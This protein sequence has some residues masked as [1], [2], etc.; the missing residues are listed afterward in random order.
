MN[1]LQ[2]TRK[3]G[4]TT[5]I[6]ISIIAVAVY[7]GFDPLFDRVGGGVAGAVVGASFGAIF[8]IVLTMYLLNKQT[9]IEQESKKSERVFDEKVKLYQQ[10]LNNT[11]EMVED[12][13][14]STSEIAQL[15]FLMMELQMLGGDETISTYE[16]VFSTINEIFEKNEEEDIVA[17]DEDEKMQIY[18]KMGD[19]ARHC[20]VDLGVS[21]REINKELFDRTITTI[22]KS[23]DLS[24]AN[25][26]R[27]AN[28]NYVENQDIFFKACEEKG[29]S[30]EIVDSTKK[31]YNALM[32]EYSSEVAKEEFIIDLVVGKHQST[33]PKLSVKAA[34][35]NSSKL[36]RICAIHVGK[37]ELH[38]HNVFKSPKWD[39]KQLK[40][41][42]VF[43]KH[44][45]PYWKKSS[46]YNEEEESIVY[47][48]HRDYLPELKVEEITNLDEITLKILL[49]VIEESKKV[50][51]ESK[52][53][54]RTEL[55]KAA[56]KGDEE[57]K[58][59]IKK[60]IAED[61]IEELKIEQI[62]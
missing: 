6:A 36:T 21:D 58:N 22:Q 51:F 5:L 49:F 16:D 37:N 41:G 32:Q 52:K 40:I 26:R 31:F 44:A 8:V 4:V 62:V 30:K 47:R 7:F 9:E 11:K 43:V 12:G 29:R 42:D 45:R 25:R 56:E 35:A 28:A 61:Y 24:M 46:F 53:L 38:L 20:R 39:Y 3:K 17:I 54:P 1:K 48:A 57:S 55:L 50:V 18:R 13:E 60:Y 27:S 14:I 33:Y 10:I 2:Q 19:F 59:T 15:P 34:Q 23:S